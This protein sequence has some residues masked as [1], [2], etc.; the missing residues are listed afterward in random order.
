MSFLVKV[1]VVSGKLALHGQFYQPLWQA[2]DKSKGFK[3]QLNWYPQKCVQLFFLWWLLLMY[4]VSWGL[5]MCKLWNRVQEAAITLRNKK[6]AF[7]RSQ[8]T[9]TVYLSLPVCVSFTWVKEKFRPWIANNSL[10][11]NQPS[12]SED[13]G[14]RPIR[15]IAGLVTRVEST[16]PQSIWMP[17]I[18]WALCYFN[19]NTLVQPHRPNIWHPRIDEMSGCKLPQDQFHKHLQAQSYPQWSASFPCRLF[20]GNCLNCIKLR[21]TPLLVALFGAHMDLDQH[22]RM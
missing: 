2:S 4:P 6:S 1:S 16:S 8:N 3:A 12:N 11:S 15:P 9:S 14:S 22:V 21:G 13:S 5:A 10:S 7:T 17:G 20:E 19:E 18:K